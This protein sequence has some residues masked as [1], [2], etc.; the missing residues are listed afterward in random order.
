MQELWV[1]ALEARR[2]DV[3]TRW[4][5]LLR[6]ER[7]NTPLAN[8]DAL[9]H[10]IDS[11]LA[12]IF[13]ALMHPAARRKVVHAADFSAVR[14]KCVCGRNPYLT[15]FVAGEQALLE[16]LVLAQAEG[17]PLDPAARDAAV[18]ELYGVMRAS[19]RREIESFCSLCQYR[20]EALAHAHTDELQ[21]H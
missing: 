15:Y 14:A 17:P 12:E 13:S 6:T 11:T 10:L 19:A 4:E 16:A 20:S 18:Q 3:R 7:V 5:D 2:G 8:P 21:H 1:H 9:V